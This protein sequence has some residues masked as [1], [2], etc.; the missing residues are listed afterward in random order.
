VQIEPKTFSKQSFS[1]ALVS[2]YFLAAKR[3]GG[4]GTRINRPGLI[5]RVVISLKPVLNLFICK[6]AT[7]NM[8]TEDIETVMLLKIGYSH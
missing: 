6:K 1:P 7:L 3:G 5:K 8:T 4:R 2:N